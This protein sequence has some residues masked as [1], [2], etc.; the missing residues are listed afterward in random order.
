MKKDEHIDAEIFELFLS[1]EVYLEY[2]RIYLKPEQID[3]V[4]IKTYL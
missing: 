3:K 2:A 1:S 4:D